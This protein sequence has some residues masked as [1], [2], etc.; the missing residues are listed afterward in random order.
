MKRTRS[1]SSAFGVTTRSFGM[2]TRIFASVA[3]AVAPACSDPRDLPVFFHG[4]ANPSFGVERAEH[5]FLADLK[6]MGHPGPVLTLEPVPSCRTEEIHVA[7]EG[8]TESSFSEP[9]VAQAFRIEDERCDG[10]H[11][12]L[13]D[14]GSELSRQWAIYALLETLGV[15]YFHPEA[16]WYPELLDW[17][18]SA[19]REERPFFQE[20]ALHVHRTHPV[21]L[22]PPLETSGLDMAGFQRRWID[23]NVKRRST[24]V[25][26]YDE[27]LVGAYAFV[28]GF[29]RTTGINLLN[30]QQG[31]RP[32]LDP[33][34]PRG[35]EEQLR[36]AIARAMAAPD[37]QP[38]PAELVFQF[39]PSEFTV[40]DEHD[41]VRRLTYISNLFA[42][43][44]PEAR[45]YAINHGTHQEP[46]IGFGIRFFDLIELAPPNLGAEVHTLM[47][48]DLERD[49][50]VYGN[51]SFRHLLAWSREQAAVRRVKHYPESSWWLTFDLPVP[52]FLAPVTLDARQRDIDLLADL[53]VSD[54][55]AT[56]G[57]QGHRLFSSGQEWGYWLIDYC[58][59]RMTWDRGVTANRCVEDFASRFVRGARL[60]EILELL[61]SAQIADFRNPEVLRYLVGSDRETEVAFDAGIVFHPLPP[62]P[63][64]VTKMDEASLATLERVS[65]PRLLD[66]SR[67]T[68]AWADELHAI[69]QA[70][71]ESLR[72]WARE[73]ADGVRVYGLRA[74]HAFEI[75]STSVAL[76]RAMRTGDLDAVSEAFAGLER[77]RAVTELAASVV[78][79]REAEY[80]YPPALTIAG[81]EPGSPSAIA[82]RTV[83]PYRYLSRTH[84]MFYWQRPDEQLGEL[85]GEGLEQVALNRRILT[86]ETP[87]VIR[88]LLSGLESLVADYGDGTRSSTLAPHRYERQG[89]YRVSLDAR[90]SGGV[91]HH[92]DE[93]GVVD[94]RFLFRR[95]SLKIIHPEG[96]RVI[97]GLLPGF[98]V[99]FGTD[100]VESW[101]MGTVDSG[102]VVTR[103]TLLERPRRGMTSPSADLDLTLRDAGRIRAYGAELSIGA[104]ETAELELHGEL[105]TEEII[106]LVVSVGGFE[107]T[108]ARALVAR[109]LEHT[110]E[111]LPDRIPFLARAR[112]VEGP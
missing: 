102:E 51:E 112:G 54:P 27:D 50:P 74:Q 68:G 49:A 60:L 41:T 104:S 103:G 18:M 76:G 33:D 111:S 105:R 7:L 65:I 92:E 82:N 39:N 6:R 62:S 31:G 95:G 12:L 80:R 97:E 24:T 10:G 84:R 85:F 56:A 38:E 21:E 96:A 57:I 43:T 89:R 25:D 100:P 66:I 2:S 15:R 61:R 53:V 90:H 107:A 45:L 81:G 70:Q 1:T 77:A 8:P 110:P 9:G 75:Y 86:L 26:G 99:G 101:L 13:L 20:R 17:P 52:L 71:P 30:S 5:D 98:V 22:S 55:T 63:R 79:A 91:L 106:E 44:Y 37:G 109:A 42:E 46:T 11:R 59:T 73:L 87:L 29:P 69:A 19:A 67:E 64:D 14:G 3:F 4:I 78:H 83:Y 32:V 47:F 48:Y 58:V 35:E 93:V 34:D 16:T 36:V 40:A 23:W 88:T 94:R 108:G 72:P 28:R